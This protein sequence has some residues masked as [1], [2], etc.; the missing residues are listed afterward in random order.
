MDWLLSAVPFQRFARLF[1]SFGLNYFYQGSRYFALYFYL[2]F[3]FFSGYRLFEHTLREPMI[4]AFHYLPSQSWISYFSKLQFEHFQT[5]PIPHLGQLYFWSSTKE[6]FCSLEPLC[7]SFP[8]PS[9]TYFGVSLS[10]L[11]CILPLRPNAEWWFAFFVMVGKMIWF[12]EVTLMFSS[13]FESWISIFAT[14]L[15]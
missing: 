10:L 4:W 11:S 5:V 12:L 15:M 14:N 7:H 8:L 3:L 13:L 2:I 9:W 6:L 1:V